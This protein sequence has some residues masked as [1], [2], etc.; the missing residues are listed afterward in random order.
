MYATHFT[1]IIILALGGLH[2]KRNIW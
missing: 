2:H 1:N